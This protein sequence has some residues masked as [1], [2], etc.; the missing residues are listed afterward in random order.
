MC[1]GMAHVMWNGTCDMKWHMSYE[2]ANVMCSG[3]CV[4][5]WHMSYEMAHVMW[6]GADMQSVNAL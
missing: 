3:T 6:N 2:M 4:V 1:C 5:E